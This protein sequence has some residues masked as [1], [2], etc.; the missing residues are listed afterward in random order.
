MNTVG[1]ALT[2]LLSQ[3]RVVH[4]SMSNVAYSVHFNAPRHYGLEPDLTVN[5]NSGQ[6]SGWAGRGWNLA[7]LSSIDLH[8]PRGGIPDFSSLDEYSLD[9]SRL[10]PCLAS[11]VS[12][13]CTHSGNYELLE[14]DGSKF[15][16]E[17]TSWQVWKTNGVKFRYDE[18]SLSRFLLTSVTDLHGNSVQYS[19]MGSDGVDYLTA[20]YYGSASDKTLNTVIDFHYQTISNPYRFASGFG[21]LAR[22]ELRPISVDVHHDGRRIRVISLSYGSGRLERIQEFGSDATLNAWDGVQSGSALPP[23]TFDYF[24]METNTSKDT[25]VLFEQAMVEDPAVD[26]VPEANEVHNLTIP[27]EQYTDTGRQN[28][29]SIDLEGDGIPELFTSSIVAGQVELLI[30]HQGGA[31]SRIPTGWAASGNPYFVFPINANGDKFVDLL[32]FSDADVSAII[33]SKVALGGENGFSFGA[34][35]VASIPGALTHRAVHPFVGDMNGDSLSD[36][37]VLM[38]NDPF[39]ETGTPEDNLDIRFIRF[40]ATGGGGFAP[41]VSS[42]LFPGGCV[43]NGYCATKN[44]F[45]FWRSGD[46]NGDGLMDLTAA[47]PGNYA[48]GQSGCGINSCQLGTASIMLSVLMSRD[49]TLRSTTSL[50]PQWC[51]PQFYNGGW[52]DGKIYT[53][54]NN[55]T[56]ANATTGDFDGDGRTDWFLARVNDG[57][58]RYSIALSRGSGKFESGL[59][60]ASGLLPVPLH[61]L[62]LPFS[63]LNTIGSADI[64][65]DGLDDL[66]ISTPYDD[67]D[68]LTARVRVLWLRSVGSGFFEPAAREVASSPEMRFECY[69]DGSTANNCLSARWSLVTANLSPGPNLEF[70]FIGRQVNNQ[71]SVVTIAHVDPRVST[72]PNELILGDIDGDGRN[73]VV[74][75]RRSADGALVEPA[76]GSNFSGHATVAT[77]PISTRDWS[78]YAVDYD[79][80]T[81][82]GPSCT[83]SGK[84]DGR[85]DLLF[86]ANERGG[87]KLYHVISKGDGTFFVPTPSPTTFP[88]VTTNGW[89]VGDFDGD[90]A[91]ELAKLSPGFP[92]HTMTTLRRST[93][94][95]GGWVV[96][97]NSIS[98]AGTFVRVSTANFNGDDAADFYVV[99]LDALG[100]T[101]VETLRLVAG[102][103]RRVLTWPLPVGVDTRTSAYHWLFADVNV[104]GVTDLVQIRSRAA[105]TAADQAVLAAQVAQSADI[106]AYNAY[107][108]ALAAGLGYA[109][110]SQASDTAR[111]L[112]LAGHSV[113]VTDSASLDILY[114]T[115]EGGFSAEAAIVSFPTSTNLSEAQRWVAVNP[116]QGREFEFQ[117]ILPA[118]LV[119]T[120]FLGGLGKIVRSPAGTWEGIYVNQFCVN[121]NCFTTQGLLPSSPIDLTG[122]GIPEFAHFRFANGFV[123]ELMRLGSSVPLL[124]T[125]AN[126]IGYKAKV[127]YVSSAGHHDTYIPGQVVNSVASIEEEV[128]PGGPA[129]SVPPPPGFALGTQYITREFDWS[130]L[131]FSQT[132][133]EGVGFGAVKIMSKETS[134]AG[135]TYSYA[136][137]VSY[138]QAECPRRITAMK[139]VSYPNDTQTKFTV[140]S[141]RSRATSLPYSHCVAEREWLEFG[142]GRKTQ[143][144]AFIR[145]EF[146]NVTLEEALGEY[147]G[148]LPGA[149]RY[150]DDNHRIV[151]EFAPI[152]S[153][154]IADAPFRTTTFDPSGQMLAREI[155]EY[156]NLSAGQ[157]AIHRDMTRARKWDDEHAREQAWSYEYDSF[158]NLVAELSPDGRTREHRIE[159]V[160]HKFVELDCVDRLCSKQTWD[161]GAEQLASAL[162]ANRVSQ[163]FLYDVF[164]RKTKQS[165]SNGECVEYRYL[166]YGTAR[167]RDVV[168]V[169]D[170]S[171][172]DGPS[173]MLLLDTYFD[174]LHRPAREVRASGAWRALAY[175]GGDG[176]LLSGSTE[177][178]KS[179][180][181]WNWTRVSHDALG[182]EYSREL[183]DG[184][185]FVSEWSNG[186]HRVTDPLQRSKDYYTNGWGRAS[187]FREYER[188]A[189][190][191]TEYHYDWAG[192][193]TRL[194]DPSGNETTNLWSSMGRKLQVC[195]PSR[196]CIDYHY[197]ADGLLDRSNDANGDRISYRYD[198]AGRRTHRND[199]H[200]EWAE[201]VYDSDPAYPAAQYTKGRLV[202]TRTKGAVTEA[203]SYDARGR[204][205][206]TT[207]CAASVCGTMQYAYDGWSG[208]RTFV[209]Y[210]DQAGNPGGEVVEYKF[211]L[212]GQVASIPGYAPKVNVDPLGRI[213]RIE[214]A[215]GAI[216]DWHYDTR[217]GWADEVRVSDSRNSVLLGVNYRYDS[218]GQLIFRSLMDPLGTQRESKFH[219]DDLGRFIRETDVG[220]GSDREKF[221]YDEAGNIA[222]SDQQGNYSYDDLTKP[223]T[224]SN[225][226]AGQY[227]HDAIGNMLDGFGNR[228]DWNAESLL[229][230]AYTSG[231]AIEYEYAADGVRVLKS[232]PTAENYYFDQLLERRDGQFV[233]LVYLGLLPVAERNKSDVTYFHADAARNIRVATNQAGAVIGVADYSAYGQRFSS[234][235][236]E[237]SF[238]AHHFDAE[239]GLL[240][241]NARYMS[242]ELGRFV[243][244][245]SIEPLLGL[246]QGLNGFAYGGNNPYSYFD[247][248][249]HIVWFIAAAVVVGLAMTWENCENTNAAVALGPAAQIAP[250]GTALWMTGSSI[251]HNGKGVGELSSGIVA[252]VDGRD[253]S[254]NFESAR[255]NFGTALMDAVGARSILN[256][257]K[258]T[259]VT[260]AP[261]PPKEGIYEFGVSGWLRSR[262]WVVGRMSDPHETTRS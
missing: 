90:G 135:H 149:D 242:P 128:S 62:N 79:S 172:R 31:T 180:N 73:D 78:V 238:S 191:D 88:A 41:A 138:S 148:V 93:S 36:L 42:V 10:R 99:S 94:P 208:L 29:T 233:N 77:V 102:R 212:D 201:W 144:R 27:Y 59:N 51:S 13:S 206:Q 195:D 202:A 257:P 175:F 150:A 141:D 54:Y 129:G 155:I 200:G 241:A 256:A 170:A 244:A 169:C 107:S 39:D 226:S 205:A 49:G 140:W 64:D 66:V 43:A 53:V 75:V 224:V 5:Y 16:K 46:L 125:V 119:S 37:G 249:G 151:R 70:A 85:A 211:D 235:S 188:G 157:A 82:V 250:I 120:G 216:Q 74:R 123:A 145:D 192:R 11:S 159:D 181:S 167:Q 2:L 234:L 166:D 198:S 87:V 143:M 251:V 136:T 25:V 189:T 130:R 185:T 156:D 57:F 104:D 153:A 114:G 231:G 133:R 6:I 260:N 38:A 252:E 193:V 35:V 71:N 160:H 227:R 127:R 182:H 220:V 32:L 236:T 105:G 158:G 18:G 203:F 76:L 33:Y 171:G 20:I 67:N 247:Q 4:D 63:V 14:D 177:W 45:G 97:A 245:D 168:D 194:V 164:G 96:E 222:Y 240:Y 9:G 213:E 95:A 176:E 98:S 86:L 65:H 161:F 174:G 228:F 113:I 126:G 116:S 186:Y 199:S 60:S 34:N 154:Y 122:D 124:S 183:P 52:G 184:A 147:V 173:N 187:I 115:G 101:Q 100:R 190:L 121:G 30:I 15:L 215:N 61:A 218:A 163:R 26:L 204:P 219:Y 58:P 259:R 22:D 118:Q 92:L 152:S 17:G 134:R 209:T 12:A 47:F 55:S 108:D 246:S 69:L 7:C 255:D 110:A 230:R 44:M 68:G 56:S 117:A 197:F 178:D 91:D 1:L 232:G 72:S 142:S 162:D 239:T 89:V 111:E 223:Y 81:C 207:R 237:L 210:P 253:G 248:D 146:G 196:G 84:K 258:V 106:V 221:R 103:W 137:E 48:C 24:A 132:L 243:S 80:A 28:W 112:Y 179:P 19:Y 83:L 3:G 21:W 165:W 214:F 139:G 261:P 254:Q 40:I 225:T 262:L 23:Y 217:R 131:V 50:G 229:E 109:T 8:S